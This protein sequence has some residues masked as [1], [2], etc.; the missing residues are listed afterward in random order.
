MQ[1]ILQATNILSIPLH[2]AED[3]PTSER[4]QTN[5]IAINSFPAMCLFHEYQNVPRHELSKQNGSLQIHFFIDFL[6]FAHSPNEE[7][8]FHG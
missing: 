4:N 8:D 1:R 3:K 6:R 5:D 2:L 7:T